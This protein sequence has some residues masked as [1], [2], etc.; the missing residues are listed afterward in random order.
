MRSLEKAGVLTLQRGAHGGASISKG[1]QDALSQGL[2]DLLQLRVITMEQLTEARVLLAE[3]I[4][5]T[6]CEKATD[7][8]FDALGAQRR[9]PR[10]RREAHRVRDASSRARSCSPVYR[11]IPHVAAKQATHSPTPYSL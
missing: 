4:T 3:I 9:S 10:R 8:D 5:R 6:A 11:R 2:G 7:E 1:N